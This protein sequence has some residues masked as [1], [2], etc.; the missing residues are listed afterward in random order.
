[1]V[2]GGRWTVDGGRWT[3]DGGRSKRE[4][5]T[6]KRMGGLRERGHGGGRCTR[7][8]HLG[9]SK[10]ERKDPHQR[11]DAGWEKSK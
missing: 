6:E 1:M 11:P 2:D 8:G 10:M 5:E 4:G 7:A 9:Q 3:V